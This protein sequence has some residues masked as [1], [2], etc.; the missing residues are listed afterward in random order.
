[1]RRPSLRTEKSRFYILL[2]LLV[3]S[4]ALAWTID[5]GLSTTLGDQFS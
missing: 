3:L 2:L 5:S 1:M 4:I